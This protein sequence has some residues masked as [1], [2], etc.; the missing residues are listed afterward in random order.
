MAKRRK[1]KKVRVPKKY[2]YLDQVSRTTFVQDKRT[3]KMKG[4]KRTKAPGDKTRVRRVKK[5][6]WSGIILGRAPVK[7]SRRA[8]A[9]S[10]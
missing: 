10:R 7:A 3:G 6:K 1:K 4:R 9:Y 8:R 5:G 2:I